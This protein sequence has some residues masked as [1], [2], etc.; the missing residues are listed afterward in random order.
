MS[1]AV[2]GVPV[3][4]MVAPVRDDGVNGSAFTVQVNGPIPPVTE[5]DSE[6]ET[7]VTIGCVGQVPVIDRVPAMVMVQGNVAGASFVNVLSDNVTMKAYC[8][9]AGVPCTTAVEPVEELRL[10]PIF[11]GLMSHR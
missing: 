9:A 3:R 5:R 1:V 4:V 2:V 7:P 11:V 6:N 10:S 8:P